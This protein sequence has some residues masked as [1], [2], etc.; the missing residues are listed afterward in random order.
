MNKARGSKDSSIDKEFSLVN[1]KKPIF[2]SIK[3]S[4]D[5]E[6]K[7]LNKKYRKKDCPTDVL[8]FNID[9]NADE[10][11]YLGE[12]VVNKDQAMRQAPEYGNSL[13]EEIAQLVEHGMLH[14]LG[15]HHEGDEDH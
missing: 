8:S 13:E 2:V 10:G 15:V 4:D 12:I 14:L 1:T 3:V 11:Y 6:T 5:S 9:E 7:S